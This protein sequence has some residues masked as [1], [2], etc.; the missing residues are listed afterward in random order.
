MVN[1]RT[2]GWRNQGPCSGRLPSLSPPFA[3]G[4]LFYKDLST[5]CASVHACPG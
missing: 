4:V 1:P 2:P 3:I 5:R